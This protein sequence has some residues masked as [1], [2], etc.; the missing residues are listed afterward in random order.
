MLLGLVSLGV[1]V[2]ARLA[3]GTGFVE[4]P[5]DALL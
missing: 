5:L 4:E 1:S 3:V 2:A